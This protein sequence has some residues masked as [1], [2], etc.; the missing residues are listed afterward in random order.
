MSN[1]KFMSER[2][3]RPID[4]KDRPPRTRIRVNLKTDVVGMFM[5][6]SPGGRPAEFI[7]RGW[8]LAQMKEWKNYLPDPPVGPAEPFPIHLLT[9]HRNRLIYELW[10]RKGGRT[11]D[12]LSRRFDLHP[13]TI[14]AIIR[15]ERRRLMSRYYNIVT[16]RLSDGNWMDVIEPLDTPLVEPLEAH[17]KTDQQRERERRERAAERR[18]ERR[19]N[20]SKMQPLQEPESSQTSGSTPDGSN[21]SSSPPVPRT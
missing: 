10:R 18:R 11:I 20:P 6:R 5:S 2:T 4:V 13:G 17:R 12:Y 9:A 1:L 8:S 3:G 14:K 19:L 15:D 16:I 7:P 21:S